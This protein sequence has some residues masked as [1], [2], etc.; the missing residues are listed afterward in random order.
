MSEPGAEDPPAWFQGPE[1]HALIEAG[2]SRFLPAL[3]TLCEEG[4]VVDRVFLVTAGAFAIT[5]HIQG[6]QYVLSTC[7]PGTLLALMP[8][9]DG[10]PCAVSITARD[11]ATV[12]EIQRDRLLALLDQPWD[13]PLGISNRLSLLAIRRLRKA[14]DELAQALHSAIG[15]PE[16]RGRM[17]AMRLARIQ[18]GGYAWLGL[19]PERESA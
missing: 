7:G 14:T 9:L 11:D 4:Q 3:S 13:A 17:N 5:K 19:Q 6:E 10:G 8:A 18:A 15:S 16:Q 1:A 2:Q 12:V